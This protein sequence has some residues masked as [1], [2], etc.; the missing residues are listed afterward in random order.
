MDDLSAVRVLEV[1]DNA[2]WRRLVEAH[3]LESSVR[4]VGTAVDGYEAVQ[5]ARALRPDVIVMDIWMPG[6]NGLA[7]AREIGEFAPES[8]ILFVS[9]ERDPA[10]VQAAFAAGA[11]G[12]MLKRLAAT[13]L[14]KAIA[15]IVRGELFIGCGLTPGA[16]DDSPPQY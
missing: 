14:V 12:Y 6:L 13:E 7:A 15:A 10:I 3:L 8:K 9:N 5:K 11:R 16:S 4:L 2:P 1:D